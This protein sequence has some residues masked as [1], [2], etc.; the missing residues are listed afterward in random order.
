[1]VSQSV[2]RGKRTVRSTW[3]S[4]RGISTVPESPNSPATVTY[5]DEVLRPNLF[6][7]PTNRTL[8]TMAGVEGE[9][10]LRWQACLSIITTTYNKTV[11]GNL[12]E[13]IS[14]LYKDFTH[15]VCFLCE[16]SVHVT[17]LKDLIG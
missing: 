4:P 6:P 8:Y 3:F 1:M 2:W 17:K 12:I 7:S 15:K 10:G 11:G 13:G 14:L 5:G 16:I 9:R